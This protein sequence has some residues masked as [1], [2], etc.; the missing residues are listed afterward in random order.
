MPPRRRNSVRRNAPAAA[1]RANTI[2]EV[3]NTEQGIVDVMHTFGIRQ[4]G[5]DRLVDDGFNSM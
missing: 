4:V 5:I 3:Y 1:E 2:T